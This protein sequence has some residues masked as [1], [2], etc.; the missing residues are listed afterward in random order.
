MINNPSTYTSKSI[1]DVGKKLVTL[2]IGKLVMSDRAII[3]HTSYPLLL[4]C[5]T[6][7]AKCQVN[8]H[9]G[10]SILS[11]LRSKVLHWGQA[12]L[13]VLIMTVACTKQPPTPIFRPK[14]DKHPCAFTR[15][16]TVLAVGLQNT[17]QTSMI[18]VAGPASIILSNLSSSG[19]R[20]VTKEKWN[21]P[22]VTLPYTIKECHTANRTPVSTTTG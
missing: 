22:E 14:S 15:H 21:R 18:A 2:R 20:I 1:V 12:V 7:T 10:A 17:S 6:S 19:T 13:C 3:N 5:H 11:K 4:Y 9:C 16:S 8:S